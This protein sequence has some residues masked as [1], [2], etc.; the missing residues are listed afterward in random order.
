MNIDTRGSR[1]W[2]IFG[3]AE[4]QVLY[5]LDTVSY[6]HL[7][8]YKRQGLFGPILDDRHIVKEQKNRRDSEFFFVILVWYG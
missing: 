8:V 3:I 4:L 5:P 6:T 1:F 2:I 7:D